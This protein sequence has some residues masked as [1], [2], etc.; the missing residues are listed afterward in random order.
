MKESQGEVVAFGIMEAKL[1]KADGLAVLESIRARY[2][3]KPV[4]LVTGY[5]E[6]M[7][8]SIEKGLRIGAYT[9]LYKPL[10]TEALIGLIREISGKKLWNV[11]G[12]GA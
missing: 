3:T 11:L 12:E 2:P 7:R 4:V 1:G 8:A 5:K 9:C 10:E 6:D